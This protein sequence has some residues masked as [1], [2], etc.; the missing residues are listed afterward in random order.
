MNKQALRKK[1]KAL[2]KKFTQEEIEEQS[3][4]IANQLLTLP[5]W[6]FLNYHVFLTIQHQKEINTEYILHILQ[7]KD[8]NIIVPKV[9]ENSSQ[10]NHYLLQDHT[11]LKPSSYGVPEPISGIKINPQEVDVVFIPLLAYDIYG[12]RVGYGKGYYDR[13]LVQCNKNALFIGLSFFEPEE[14]I[15]VYT[16][17]IALDYCITPLNIYTFKK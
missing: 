2:R 11:V 9:I 4:N 8:K 14:H 1:Y 3:L 17:D 12:N 5:I 10:M 16:N 15:E 7:G 6:N 13:F